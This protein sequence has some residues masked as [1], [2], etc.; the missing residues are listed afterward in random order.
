MIAIILIGFFIGKN[1]HPIVTFPLQDKVAKQIIRDLANNQTHKVRFG[2]HA[3]QRMTERNVTIRQVFDV[4]KSANSYFTE[5]PHPTPGG[6]W[7]CN[8][9]GIAAGERIEVVIVLKECETEP[10]AYIVT[11]MVK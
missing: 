4:L 9:L 6:S 2:Q 11:V 8:L 5:R 10:N 3:K 1:N 7:K